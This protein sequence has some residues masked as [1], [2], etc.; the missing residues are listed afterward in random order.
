[1]ILSG[2]LFFYIVISFSIIGPEDFL[3]TRLNRVINSIIIFLAMIGFGVSM[4]LT[5][6]SS[7]IVDERDTLIQ[8]K[9]T[10]TGMMLTCIFVFIITMYLFVQNEDLGT[11]NVSW[12]WVIAYGTFS[13]SYFVTS[14]VMILLYNRED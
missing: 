1:M 11:V 13:F 3:S 10:S 2:I 9:A 14:T 6:K 12:M 4:L 7:N 8:K 5:N